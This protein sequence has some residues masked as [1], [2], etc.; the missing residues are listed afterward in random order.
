MDIIKLEINFHMSLDDIDALLCL[1]R[2]GL[3]YQDN[4]EFGGLQLDWN[5]IVSSSIKLGVSGPLYDGLNPLCDGRQVANLDVFKGLNANSPHI[6]L[7]SAI[8]KQE[9]RYRKQLSVLDDISA[10]FNKEGIRLLLIKGIGISLLYPIPEHRDSCDI[11]YYLFGDSQRGIDC[12]EKCGC[13]SVFSSHHHSKTTYHGVSLENH[14][15]FLDRIN[16]KC[17]RML[18]DNLKQMAAAG[19]LRRLSLPGH[20][21][22]NVFLPSATMN[23]IFLMRHMSGHFAAEGILIRHF[24]DWAL[25]LNNNSKEIDWDVVIDLYCK[26]GMMEFAQR[27]Q[28]IITDII[29]IPVPN[30][31]IEGKKGTL[32]DRI[33]RDTLEKSLNPHKKHSLSFYIFELGTFFKSKWKYR[34]VY[35]GESYIGLFF[36]YLPQVFKTLFTRK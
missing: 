5:S 9:Q 28:Y 12:L 16:H 7:C 3:G 8:L 25:F 4:V 27:T 11:D 21:F 19:N 6:R 14:Y 20:D 18:D 36:S 23:A 32:S 29:K 24:I 15:D 1:V 2:V 26:S 33:W 31:P 22:K 13:P 10:L 30:V 17:N 34:L 35:P